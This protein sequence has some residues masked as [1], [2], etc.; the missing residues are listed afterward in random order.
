MKTGIEVS[1]DNGVQPTTA[2]SQQKGPRGEGRTIRCPKAARAPF[3]SARSLI[4]THGE[5]R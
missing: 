1:E 3:A 5:C 4:T 2:A